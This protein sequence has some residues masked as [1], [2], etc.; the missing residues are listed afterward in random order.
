MI[1]YY[2]IRKNSEDQEIFGVVHSQ[3][4]KEYKNGRMLAENDK[5]LKNANF[6]IY[7]G[8]YYRAAWMNQIPGM[9]NKYP[10]MYLTNITEEQYLDFLKNK[11]NLV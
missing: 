5:N 10:T 11:K 2:E 8:E 7:E 9:E 6:F 3:Y 1:C 4:F